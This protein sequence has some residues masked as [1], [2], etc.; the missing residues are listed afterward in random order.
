MNVSDEI[1]NME[2]VH[3]IVEDIENGR[4]MI[5][6]NLYAINREFRYDILFRN[7]I[8]FITVKG[9]QVV[10]NLFIQIGVKEV[11]K[12]TKEMKSAI[13]DFDDEAERRGIPK[14]N[15]GE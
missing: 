4:E 11:R 8:K 2:H 14:A 9:R 10:H 7:D 12:K 3:D 15:R 13:I 5:V 1:K 6:N